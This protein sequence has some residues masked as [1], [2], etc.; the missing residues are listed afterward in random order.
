MAQSS[1]FARLDEDILIEFIYHD[2]HVD[3]VENSKIENDD[4]GSQLKYLNTVNGDSSADIFLINELGADVV[5]FNVEVG[6]G[7]V[8]INNFASRGLTLK[9]GLTY[10][11]NLSDSSI[12]NVSGF[13]II[14]GT[15]QLN[16][17]V[18]T[19]T[20][21]TNG[22]YKYEYTDISS[23]DFVG[24]EIKV[25]NKANSLYAKSEKETGNT[26]KTAPGESGRYY[27]V[28]TEDSKVF[29]LLDNSLNYLDS[30][31][32]SGTSSSDLTVVDVNDVQHVYYD[33]IRLHLRTGYSF[34]GRDLEGFL[35]QVRSLRD[36]GSYGYSTSIVYK[37]SSSFEIQNPKPFV[38]SDSSFSKYIEI[39]VPSLIHMNSVNKNDEFASTFY[40]DNQLVNGANYEIILST[41]NEIKTVNGY[42]YIEIATEQQLTLS[43][44]DEFVD[45]SINVEESNNGDY[46]ELYGTK[47]GDQSGFERY[48]LELRQ[49]S[50]DDYIVF[51]D[52][53]VSEQLGLNYITTENTTLVQTD[54]YSE[55]LRFRPIIKNAGFCSSFLIRVAMR[56]YNETNN[57]QILKVATLIYDKPKKYGNFM[58]Q[59]SLTNNDSSNIVYN[60]LPNTSDSKQ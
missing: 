54:N 51:Y 8:Y 11:F 50:G 43:E 58:Q 15:T 30:T 3:I 4:N 31:E 2:Q 59:I 37:N 57:T 6:N 19:Y 20:P 38:L 28:P 35:F 47:D 13:T 45:L 1:K 60:K 46:F 22:T 44:E 10:K 32:W 12:D 14:G 33:T 7:F 27:A 40:G 53:E 25:G 23:N 24:G 16:G 48:M 9:N 26:I 5:N 55:S 49:E 39:R 18:L 17:N 56:I 21:N 42:E 29:A 36:N 41:I 52:I 34:I